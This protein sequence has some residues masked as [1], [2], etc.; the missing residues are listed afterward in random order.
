[1]KAAVDPALK[2]ADQVWIAAALLHRENPDRMDF[3]VDEILERAHKETPAG[4]LR[5]GVRVHILQHCVANRPANPGRYR[6]LYETGRGRRRL[7]RSGDTFHP[8]RKGGKVVPFLE[9]VPEKYGVL[10]KWYEREYDV[11]RPADE[12][13]SI[14]GLRGLG[15]EIW[16]GVD[17]DEYVRELREGWE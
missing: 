11:R 5:P 1:M 6:M 17:P 7:F 4:E 13:G 14:L 2:V 15:K 8:T 3:T 12:C 10:L 9:E 16:K